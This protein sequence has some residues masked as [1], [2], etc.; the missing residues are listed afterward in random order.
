MASDPQ[1]QHLEILDKAD[2]VLTALESGERTASELAELTGEPISTTY[3]LIRTLLELE[4]VMPGSTRGNYR[5]GLQSLTAG[6]A[7]IDS[8]DIR[9]LLSPLLLEIRNATMLT[10]Y[11]CLPSGTD[12]VCIERHAG[13]GVRL[14]DLV[15]GGSL[16]LSAGGAPT[17]ILAGMSEHDAAVVIDQLG[18]RGA[19]LDVLQTRLD[20]YREHGYVVSDGDVTRGVASFGA[21]VFDH[22]GRVAAS[23]SCGGLRDDVIGNDALAT[24]VIDAARQGSALLGGKGTHG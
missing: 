11:L 21:P 12:A 22:L 14:L 20:H 2:A 17:A 9:A 4:W 15:V 1:L 19:E 24:L 3:R 6:S 8:L 16:P 5:L 7:F 13:H 23:V 18:V 10:S